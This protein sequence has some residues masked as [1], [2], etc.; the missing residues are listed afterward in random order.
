[1]HPY[2]SY[3]ILSTIGVM[4]NTLA[5]FTLIAAIATLPMACAGTIPSLE[6]SYSKR[7]DKGTAACSDF[8]KKVT[9]AA[10]RFSAG[11]IA[12][13]VVSSTAILTGLA[14]E[15]DASES[16]NTFEK[17][18]NVLLAGAGAIVGVFAAYLF[19]RSDAAAAAAS[20]SQAALALEND[21]LVYKACLAAS[22]AYQGSRKDSNAAFIAG[23]EEAKKAAVAE[24]E[25]AM[26][27]AEEAT[28]AAEA[29][30][31]AAEEATNTAKDAKKTAEENKR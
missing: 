2:L 25:E 13:S 4:A 17:N 3:S 11:G 21:A 30:T 9:K 10:G 28:R 8:S 16:A 24:A 29:A 20:D 5:N 15:P 23:L 31:K 27:A 26:K 19:N 18:R 7:S 14:I 12:A 6:G 1:M 22:S